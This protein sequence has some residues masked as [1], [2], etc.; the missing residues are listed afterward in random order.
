MRR[1]WYLANRGQNSASSLLVFV[2]GFVVMFCSLS[3]LWSKQPAVIAYRYFRK[4]VGSYLLGNER[5]RTNARAL[6][7]SW[8]F[9][10]P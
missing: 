8:G 7:L 5:I 9:A 10:H 1:G 2:D 3:V 4:F 6:T